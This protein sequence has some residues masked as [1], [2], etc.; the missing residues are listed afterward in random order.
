M[1]QLSS[2]KKSVKIGSN[3]AI[4]GH[5]YI[6]DS[7]HGI[8][9]NRLIR[10]QDLVVA[11]NGIVIGEDVWIASQCSIIKGARIHDHAIIGANSLVNKEIPENAIA[12]GTP[13]KVASFRE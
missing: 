8:E 10:E 11:E 6:I 3:T 2:Q 4:A 9:A 5:C 1:A 7:N 13:A 12:F